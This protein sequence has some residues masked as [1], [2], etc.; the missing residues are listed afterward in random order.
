MVDHRHVCACRCGGSEIDVVVDVP[1]DY[2]DDRFA[3][4]TIHD[5][6]CC[7]GSDGDDQ[8]CFL[9]APKNLAPNPCYPPLC[10]VVAIRTVNVSNPMFW[11][12]LDD[13]VDEIIEVSEPCRSILFLVPSFVV[14]RR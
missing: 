3:L 10:H 11:I 9:A 7:V 4:G 1:N 14:D 8:C 2:C 12:F 5:G 6:C 13:D